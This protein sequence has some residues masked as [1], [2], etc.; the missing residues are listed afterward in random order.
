M[1][2]IS[3]LIKEI[4]PVIIGVLIALVINNWNEDRKDKKYLSQMLLSINE[5]LEESKIDIKETIPRQR[6]LLDSIEVN[7]RNET[8]SLFDIVTKANGIRFATIKNN[9]WKSIANSKIELVD[10]KK[11]SVLSEIEE[12]KKIL[13]LQSEKIYDFLI[14]NGEE[15]SQ[16]KKEIFR[17]IIM[18]IISLE[19]KLQSDIQ[20]LNKE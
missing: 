8:V 11:I 12:M 3:D 1:K 7:L 9:S 6:V 4:I 16:G 20:E 19:E 13:E 15:T 17:M 10:Y 14:N 18:N 5:E 2:K